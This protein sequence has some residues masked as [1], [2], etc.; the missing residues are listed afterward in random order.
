M[1]VWI[2]QYALTK[3][4]L[5]LEAEVSSASAQMVTSKNENG[6]VG[7]FHKPHWHE[8]KQDAIERN[9][10]YDPAALGLEMLQFDEPNLD[11]EYNTLCFFATEDGRVFTAQDSGCSC[12]CPFELYEGETQSPVVQ[13][14][15]RIESADH[16][17]SILHVW[18]RKYDGTRMLADNPEQELRE[19]CKNHLP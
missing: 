14:M 7:H 5:E 10:Y 17:V 3:G 12:P 18:N 15:E 13:L 19:W 1:K 4:I 11:Y 8:R 6:Y 9:P 2:T 16:A